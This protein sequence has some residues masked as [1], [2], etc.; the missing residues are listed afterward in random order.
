MKLIDQG[1]RILLTNSF[2]QSLTRLPLQRRIE[3]IEQIIEA[4]FGA[5]QFFGIET[6]ADFSQRMK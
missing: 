3:P 2:C 5:A 1:N 4:D 6:L